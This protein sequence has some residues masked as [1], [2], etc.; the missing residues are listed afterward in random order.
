M[1]PTYENRG[2]KVS[3]E[4]GGVSAIVDGGATAAER[5]VPPEDGS[6]RAKKGEQQVSKEGP[7]EGVKEGK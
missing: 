4:K 2:K 6:R 7:E 5:K 3:L 1:L